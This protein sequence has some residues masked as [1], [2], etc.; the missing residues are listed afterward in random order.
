M[1]GTEGSRFSIPF[2]SYGEQRCDE[3]IAIGIMCGR[4]AYRVGKD[5]NISRTLI[6]RWWRRWQEEKNLDRRKGSGRPSKTGRAEDRA[7]VIK[8]KRNRF[9]SVPRLFVSWSNA[10]GVSCSVR[11]AYR[12][13]AEAGLKFCRPVVGIPLSE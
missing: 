8:A 13:L 2:L 11:T 7:L 1:P 12:R 4:S 3:G 10:A 9:E 6:L 5:L